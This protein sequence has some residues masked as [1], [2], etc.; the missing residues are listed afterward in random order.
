VVA[1]AI[2]TARGECRD[3]NHI[4]AAKASRVAPR[5][6]GSAPLILNERTNATRA[7]KID[8]TNA[9]AARRA[10]DTLPL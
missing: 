4:M 3:S 2:S 5:L 6:I 9:M 1:E 8:S 7:H 10:P